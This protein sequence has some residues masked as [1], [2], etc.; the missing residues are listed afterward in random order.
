M[1]CRVTYFLKLVGYHPAESSFIAPGVL[2]TA[3]AASLVC[4]RIEPALEHL[5]PRSIERLS[6]VVEV[7][8]PG[9]EIVPVEERPL[10]LEV[11]I[12]AEMWLRKPGVDV[13]TV[14]VSAD[15][16]FTQ[17][18]NLYR[19][20][21][22]GNMGVALAAVEPV[23][24]PDFGLGMWLMLAGALLIGMGLTLLM[25]WAVWRALGV[26]LDRAQRLISAPLP[27]PLPSS[28]ELQRLGEAR[29]HVAL[30]L[31]AAGMSAGYGSSP[32]PVR[33]V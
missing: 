15:M 26:E 19:E 32:N 33:D 8:K 20:L 3:E 18:R 16:D 13:A 4:D 27:E 11:E 1:N 31:T 2:S 29:R 24:A 28:A 23:W 7:I 22:L 14:E 21:G 6:M 12:G 25:V 10:V 9:T 5:P 17:A 30:L